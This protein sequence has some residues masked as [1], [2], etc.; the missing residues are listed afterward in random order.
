MFLRSTGA[1]RR[2]RAPDARKPD[3]ARGGRVRL[4]APKGTPKDRLAKLV[5][6]LQ[7]SVRSEALTA[8]FARHG[9]GDGGMT[10]RGGRHPRRGANSVRG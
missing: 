7:Q 1:C 4:Y 5:R 9:A 2:L 6:A 3:R 10:R 8:A